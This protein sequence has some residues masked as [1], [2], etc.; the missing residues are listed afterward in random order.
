MEVK[1]SDEQLRH[2]RDMVEETRQEWR[3]SLIS[4][5]NEAYSMGR[6]HDPIGKQ[7]LVNAIIAGRWDA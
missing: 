5:V 4:V 1:F 7:E 6:K 3:N 2:I